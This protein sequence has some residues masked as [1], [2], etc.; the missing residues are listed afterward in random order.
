MS[1]L[2]GAAA[3]AG[4]PNLSY[5]ASGGYVAFSSTPA[6]L[7]EYLRSTEGQ[8]KTLKE[9]PGLAEAEQKV[10]GPSSSL[11][12]YENQVETSRALFEGLRKNGSAAESPSS[13][14]AANLLP[15]GLNV[16]S[17]IKSVKELMDFSLLPN[18]DSVSKYF[19]FSVYGGEANT[20]GLVFKMFSPV[21][22]GLKAP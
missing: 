3:G 2:G 11:F 9:T 12:G 21:P 5:T 6:M 1:P 19:Y 10:L 14:P 15:S 13:N 4:A 18:F 16:P 7:E 20:D 22:P 8:R 17:T